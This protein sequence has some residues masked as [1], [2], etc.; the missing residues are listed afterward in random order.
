MET[1]KSPGPQSQA[2]PTAL[3][4]QKTARQSKY[5]SKQPLP[6]SKSK[7]AKASQLQGTAATL[8]IHQALPVCCSGK[9]QG[10]S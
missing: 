6:E 1:G 7:L 5:Q 10:K 4:H 8:A 2:G 3:P 9:Q